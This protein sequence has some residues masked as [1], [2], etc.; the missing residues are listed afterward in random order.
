MRAESNDVGGI[1]AVRFAPSSHFAI[2]RLLSLPSRL[3]SYRM[4]KRPLDAIASTSTAAAP[5]AKKLASIFAQAAGAPSP[6]KATKVGKNKTCWHGVWG[7]PK[8]SNKV[9]ALDV[10]WWLVA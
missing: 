4:S 6:F 5:P 8:S 3:V 2:I 9:L 1:R 7:E 10:S